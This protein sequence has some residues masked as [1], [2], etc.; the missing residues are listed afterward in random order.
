MPGAS[1]VVLPPDETEEGIRRWNPAGIILSGGP[2]SVYDEGAP[3]P[4]T[5]PRAFGV[6]VLGLCY[7]MQWMAH[8][9]GG[10]VTPANGREYGRA[11]ARLA[12]DSELFAG[13]EPEQTV[14]MSHGDSVIKPPPGYR[15]TGS[16]PSSTGSPASSVRVQHV[17]GI[18]GGAE[19]EAHHSASENEIHRSFRAIAT[20]FAKF[21][22]DSATV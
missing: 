11:V 15:V 17:V 8:V 18:A 14:W 5:D 9:S 2:Q 3:L 20:K 19:V 16:T 13:L 10:E 12:T 22:A 7:G 21:T 4:R 1:S 6:P